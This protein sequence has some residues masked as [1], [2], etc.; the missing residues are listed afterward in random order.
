MRRLIVGSLALTVSLAVGT[1]PARS[2]VPGKPADVPPAGDKK[3]KQPTPRLPAGHALMRAKLKHS[4]AVLEGLALGDYKAIAR[5]ADELVQISRAAEF[6][7]AYKSREYAVQVNI[8][9]RAAETVSKKAKDK[10]LDG[11][12]LA[13]MDMTMT[14]LKCHQYTRDNK[15]DARLPVP[16][17]PG[18]A[19]AVR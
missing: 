19:T 14:C 18:T 16:Q 6:L 2:D 7:T 17:L 4:Q 5:S 12:T 3:D 10:N 15:T 13:Y 8:F 1:A 9:R 11:V